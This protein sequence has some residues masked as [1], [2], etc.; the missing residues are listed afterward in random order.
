M[1]KDKQDKLRFSY[2]ALTDEEIDG[3]L[4][5]LIRAIQE[6]P[7]TVKWN[8]EA[9][10]L[11]NYA[12]WKLLYK[13]GKSRVDTMRTIKERWGVSQKT[14]YLYINEAEREVNETYTE[15][16]DD[17]RSKNMERLQKLYDDAV[18]N[19]EKKIALAALEQMNKL[20]GLYTEN[21]QVEVKE[22]RFE[23]D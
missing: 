21:H 5:T 19:G 22:I 16:K 10:D 9:V 12:I 20:Q 15:M 2:D 3:K 17:Y 11:R 13:Q 4:V 1:A 8:E 14:A 18:A 23:F 6:K 7:Q